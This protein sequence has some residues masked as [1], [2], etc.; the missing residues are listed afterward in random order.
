M[1]NKYG[2]GFKIY[3][4]IKILSFFFIDDNFYENNY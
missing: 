2:I 4:M 1:N 3:P